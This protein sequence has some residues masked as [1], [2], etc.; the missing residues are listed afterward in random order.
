MFT[1]SGGNETNGITVN[2]GTCDSALKVKQGHQQ[3]DTKV[4]IEIKTNCSPRNNCRCDVS[5]VDYDSGGVEVLGLGHCK[6]EPSGWDLF[7]PSRIIGLHASGFLAAFGARWN[8][9]QPPIGELDVGFI[10]DKYSQ[11]GITW[12][13]SPAQK[14]DDAWSIALSSVT[15]NGTPIQRNG[16]TAALHTTGQSIDMPLDAA[17]AIHT[18]LGGRLVVPQDEGDPPT[19]ALPCDTAASTMALGFGNATFRLP[20]SSLIYEGSYPRMKAW[21]E[22]NT[23]QW[24]MSRIGSLPPHDD[25][26]QWHLG[27]PF[28]R[29]VYTIFD[30]DQSRVGLVSVADEVEG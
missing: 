23:Q 4:D 1:V 19:F 2:T 14:N 26:G 29:A 15:V 13:P 16:L 7:F 12:I 21:H 25:N 18:A 30:L 5:N 22:N 24:C 17:F 11:R 3:D 8:D 28:L 9:E 10:R 6:H 20:H 27:A